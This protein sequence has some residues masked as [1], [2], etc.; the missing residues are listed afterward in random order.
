MVQI[1]M[2]R[3]TTTIS[4]QKKMEQTKSKIYIARDFSGRVG[5]KDGT[6]ESVHLEK[7]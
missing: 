7:Q 6:Y 1:G 3:Y 5:K 2:T 4:K